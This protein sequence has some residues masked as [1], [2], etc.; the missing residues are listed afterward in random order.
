[1]KKQSKHFKETSSTKKSIP[2]IV[3]L[4]IFLIGTVVACQTTDTKTSG[5]PLVASVIIY[6][7]VDSLNDNLYSK[8]MVFIMPHHNPCSD[9]TGKEDFFQMKQ[10]LEA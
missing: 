9:S 3:L 4:F 5:P 2:K 8:A 6:G 7:N 1:M 10:H